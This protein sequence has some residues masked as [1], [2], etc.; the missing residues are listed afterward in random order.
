MVLQETCSRHFAVLHLHIEG[1]M[2]DR[3]VRAWGKRRDGCF[4][5]TCRHVGEDRAGALCVCTG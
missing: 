5:V 2:I 3:C 4:C 1:E